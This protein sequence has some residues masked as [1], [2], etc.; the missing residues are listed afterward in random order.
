MRD[1]RRYIARIRY[2]KIMAVLKPLP[3]TKNA[4]VLKVVYDLRKK[5]E[6]YKAKILKIES[7]NRSMVGQLAKV[8]E[9]HVIEI[10]ELKKAISR[11]NQRVSRRDARI[12]NLE[13]VNYELECEKY[14]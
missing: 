1:S 11:V 5:L 4:G 8:K 12:K 13:R 3:P 14:D 9:L 2:G 6:E 10:K 7:S